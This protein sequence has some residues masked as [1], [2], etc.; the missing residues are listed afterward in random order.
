MRV[1]VPFPGANGLDLPAMSPTGEFL[2]AQAT[3]KDGTRGIYLRNMSTGEV[4][5]MDG[6]ENV[7]Q[8]EMKFSPNGSLIA[9]TKESNGGVFV[10][11]I[12]S[13]IP[14]RITEFGRLAF[15]EDDETLIMTDD[16]PGGGLTYRVRL[17]GGEP[18]SVFVKD[19]KLEDNYSNV[20]KTNVPGSSRAFG[21]QLVRVTGGG[22]ANLPRRIYTVDLQSGELDILESN[23]INPE[24]VAGGLLTYQ[25]GGDDG[26]LLVRPINEKTGRFEGVPTDALPSGETTLWGQ[27]TV[28][29]SG[30][31]IYLPTVSNT[32]GAVSLWTVNLETRETRQVPI[33]LPDKQEPFD[34]S[35]SP[36]GKQIV[37]SSGND[38][39]GHVFMYDLVQSVQYQYTFEG[40]QFDPTFLPDGRHIAYTQEVGARPVVV[41]LPT[42]KSA[43]PTTILD[44]VFIPAFSADGRW[45][46]ATGAPPE[47]SLDLLLMD[48][49]SG[50][51]SV[52]DTTEAGPSFPS[53]SA[54]SRYVAFQSSLNGVPT[55]IVRSVQGNERFTI[56]RL[57]GGGPEWSPDGGYL[58][59][60]TLNRISRLQVRT[61]PTFN[62]LSDAE[63]I[64][65][66]PDLSGFD[67]SPDGQYLVI[68]ASTVSVTDSDETEEKFVWLQNWSQHIRRSLGD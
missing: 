2:A 25:L 36:S 64:V 49:R 28:T 3:G 58:Y 10:A 19:P 46:A 14:R 57:F 9:F 34:P 35:F 16:A 8:R 39:G 26:R 44:G 40:R 48:R 23:A 7:G 67:L 32:S 42:D 52:F 12:P 47:Y 51:I 33:R 30:D 22:L 1:E 50:A 60:G 55:L 37:F 43:G 63:T 54:D 45:M 5:F 29:P 4:R 15:W 59:F 62:I 13:G 68:A 31:L 17:D 21:H 38:D 66:A 56:P 11:V 41:Q 53:F 27:Y 65:R 20:A 18:D 6:S 61:S 24:Y